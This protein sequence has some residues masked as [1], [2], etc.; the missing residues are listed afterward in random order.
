M[1]AQRIPTGRR[2]FTL[3]EV[4]IASTIL[5]TAIGMILTFFVSALDIYGLSVG[6]LN[7]NGETRHFS[8]MIMR[9]ASRACNIAI[10][11]DGG[12]LTLNYRDI[13][14]T[15]TGAVTYVFNSATG[16]VT[17]TDLS[18]NVSSVAARGV[19]PRTPG[20]NLFNPLNT[21]STDYNTVH[22][23][24]YITSSAQSRSQRTATNIFEFAV[25]H[26]G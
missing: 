3:T 14:G 11:G 7:V 19:Q 6:K 18:T 1:Y 20:G 25:T 17:R 9:D 21:N 4:L 8:E 22:I 26:H 24:G 15:I 2:G 10:S 12:T 23:T 5:I 13:N 16:I